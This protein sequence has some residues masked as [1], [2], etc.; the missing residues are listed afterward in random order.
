MAATYEQVMEALKRADAAGN[1][2]DAK[3]LAAMAVQMRPSSASAAVLERAPRPATGMGEFL[4]ESARRGVT[5]TPAALT[6]GSAA[7]TGTFA[8]AFPA[9]PELEQVTTQ[10]V[11]RLF[12]VQPEIRPTTGTQRYLGAFVEGALDPA[13]LIGGRGLLGL[14]TQAVAG[15]VA[16]VGGEFGGEIGGQVGGLPGQIFGGVTLA[17]LSGAGAMKA[18]ESVIRKAQG[19]K[20]LDVADLANVEGLSRAKDLIGKAIEADPNLMARITAINDRLKFV[21]GAD[22]PA[23][24]TALDSPA[25]RAKLENLA[26]TDLKFR[27]DVQKLYTDLQAATRA[28][29]AELY[30]ASG[31]EMPSATAK[32]QE[33]TVD[34]NKR[35][36]AINNQLKGLTSSINL[37]GDVTP[38]NLGTSIQNLVVAR[39][40]AARAALSPEYEAVLQQASSQ[41]AMLP[42][43]QTQNLL[44]TAFDLFQKDPWARQSGLLQLVEQQSNKFKALR[45]S[46]EGVETGTTLPATLAPDLRIGLDITSLD[47]LKRRVADDIRRIKDPQRQDK[48]RVLQQRVDEALDQVQSTSGGIN[49]NLRGT[50]T[51]FG[52]AIAQLDRDYYNKVGIPFRD[53]EAVQRINSQEYAEKI[54]PQIASSP[55]ALTQFLRVS[56]DEGLQLAEKAVMSRLYN[57]SLGKDGLV[58]PAKLE[59]L[60]SKTSINGGY[61]DIVSSLPGLQQR[62]QDTVTRSQ[63]LGAER[64]AI[65]DAARAEQARIGQSFLRDYDAGGTDAVISK[66]LGATGRGY[67]NRFFTDL[68]KLSPDEKVNVQM[69]VRNQLVTTMLDSK[70]PFGFLEKN[71]DAF[72]QVFGKDHVNNLTALADTARLAKKVDIN[73][74][75]INDAAV[76]E[77]SALRRFIGGLAPQ[78]ISNIL[79]NGIYS[80]LQKGYRILGL[81]GQ[82]QIDEAT[83]QAHVKLFMDPAGVKAINEASTRL[84][85]KDGKEVD[86]RKA[87]DPND[88]A[89]LANLFG[90][91]VARTG[92]VGGA[93]AVSPSGTMEIQQEPYFMFEG[94]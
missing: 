63:A 22:Q 73:K 13:S 24:V 67:R 50:Q 68:N 53:A 47:S 25:L 41:G 14:G 5:R 26:K 86:F 15:G 34:F 59:N 32:A 7:A 61:S 1:V 87:I 65:D 4:T 42:A 62:L 19:V 8:G 2:E 28:K 84:I 17:L 74:L 33:V 45:R 57:Q 48:L 80:N 92:Y 16:S 90:L 77:E 18:T 43:Q 10:N 64:I 30:P 93:T 94:Q 3:Q 6:A 23:G 46:V 51:T 75:P 91:N 21:T 81:L 12:G 36:D 49:V 31:I 72:T 29:A 76:A 37:S 40:K 35:V 70:D 85:S 78:Q 83:R 44:D 11:Q 38:I 56:G 89:K 54:A 39:E 79:V 55:T 69:A 52:D 71:K 27:A 60:L 58:D 20:D 88:L 66:M 9:Q 82:S